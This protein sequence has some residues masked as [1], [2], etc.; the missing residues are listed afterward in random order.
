MNYYDPLHFLII[1]HP[2]LLFISSSILSISSQS[3]ISLSLLLYSSKEIEDSREV[4]I[5]EWCTKRIALPFCAFGPWGG[6]PTVQRRR[7]R[8]ATRRF[9]FHMTGDQKRKGVEKK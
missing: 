8:A 1:L 6:G 4:R 3:T 5:G 7:A 9:F 2:S